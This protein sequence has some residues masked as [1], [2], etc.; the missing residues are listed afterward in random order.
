MGISQSN[1]CFFS[2][3]SGSS[4]SKSASGRRQNGVQ[5]DYYMRQQQ[6]YSG[7]S[8]G[9]QYI[10]GMGSNSSPEDEMGL[11][12][13]YGGYPPMQ[14]GGSMVQLRQTNGGA[15]A[16]SLQHMKDREP[17]GKGKNNLYNKRQKFPKFAFVVYKNIVREILIVN[18]SVLVNILHNLR[19]N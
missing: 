4:S 19:Y 11:L 16:N 13:G 14:G 8:P 3:E 7:Q 9:H 10:V 18:K 17:E 15:N 6:S 1:C 2:R 5:H 12:G